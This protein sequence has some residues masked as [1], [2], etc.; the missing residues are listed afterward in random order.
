MGIK[1]AIVPPPI[2]SGAAPAEP[3]RKRNTMRDSRLGARAHATVEAKKPT[4]DV[5][6]RAARPYN[7]DRGAS[8]LCDS[9]SATGYILPFVELQELSRESYIGPI[10]YPRTKTET[11]NEL[12]ASLLL[13]N[14]AISSGTPGA[15]IDDAKDL[16]HLT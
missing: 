13:W 12:R 6:Y 10:A 16:F 2:A 15:H 8:T 7:S 4:L 14:S 5:W 3:A 1:S 9:P 11:T